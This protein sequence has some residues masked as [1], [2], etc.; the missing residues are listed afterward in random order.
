MH[1]A[2]LPAIRAHK[3]PAPLPPSAN[4]DPDERS[5]RV[6][7]WDLHREADLHYIITCAFLFYVF[8]CGTLLEDLIGI[9]VREYIQQ[10]EGIKHVLGIV[11]LIF[12]I[13]FVADLP[14]LATLVWSSVVVYVWFLVMSKMPAQYNIVVVL[15]L[16]V[17]F[18]LNEIIR[19]TYS[20]EWVY[21]INDKTEK[22]T[23]K[24]KRDQLATISRSVSIA[25]LALSFVLMLWFVL[26]CNVKWLKKVR[27]RMI[28]ETH[29]KCSMLKYFIMQP[30]AH[31][32]KFTTSALHSEHLPT[33]NLARL[34]KRLQDKSDEPAQQLL[35]VLKKELSAAG[36][37]AGVGALPVYR[38]PSKGP[39]PM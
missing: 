26:L 4:E 18:A 5:T 11:V 3:K 31:E 23:R 17:C 33:R 2:V 30:D 13:G 6:K 10:N 27:E 34:T 16:I 12:T 37:G 22:H 15:L 29:G 7:I 32:W 24:A 19:K 38:G 28:Q 8:M 35:A 9:N 21:E 39:S 1:A 14:S 36:A 25:T 20:P